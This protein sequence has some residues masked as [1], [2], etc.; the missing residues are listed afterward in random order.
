MSRSSSSRPNAAT[1]SSKGPNA[2]PRSPLRPDW[3]K[4]TS[5]TTKLWRRSRRSPTDFAARPRARTDRLRRL[6]QRING[7]QLRAR[8]HADA[9]RRR[10]TREKIELG[11]LV[12][13]AGLREPDRAVILGALIEAA[14]HD[15]H[16]AAV[17][18][19]R[20]IGQDAFRS[21]TRE[22]DDKTLEPT[23]R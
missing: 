18:R 17:K 13:K 20:A 9:E 14:Q 8:M 23:P 15:R 22:T 5:L 10:D 3:P 21:T 1:W 4:S 11:G 16:S 7:L 12:V 19:W 6:T 2:L